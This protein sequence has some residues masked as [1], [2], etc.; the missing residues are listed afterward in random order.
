MIIWGKILG[1]AAGFALG[2]PLGALLGAMAGHAVD[3]MQ[4]TDAV[5]KEADRDETQEIAFTVGVIV[6]AAKM[7]TA[8]G[9]IAT[10]HPVAMPYPFNQLASTY[11]GVRTGRGRCVLGDDIGLAGNDPEI[12]HIL[13]LDLA[14][15][16]C[17]P[18][19]DAGLL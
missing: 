4:M 12:A 1:G 18:S 10:G 2:G 15:D 6:L 3:S 5:A 17:I 7:A 8:D 13:V 19:D 16:L 9:K 11:N 14:F